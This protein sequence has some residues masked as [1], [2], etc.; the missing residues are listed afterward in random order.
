MPPCL[1][2][3]CLVT[4]LAQHKLGGHGGTC[5][6]T[7]IKQSDTLVGTAERRSGCA[8]VA[9]SP[10]VATFCPSGLRSRVRGS[11]G[12]SLQ[13]TPTTSPPHCMFNP[14]FR[15]RRGDFFACFC[16][17]HIDRRP[18]SR[19]HQG[20]CVL[21]GWCVRAVISSSSPPPSSPLEAAVVCPGPLATH[22][23][24]Q[25]GCSA[26]R[27]TGTIAVRAVLQ[28]CSRSAISRK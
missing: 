5:Q 22:T 1:G 10:R 26:P 3:D 11:C 8:G 19:A 28:P 7:Q 25:F 21:P 24:P 2:A 27:H 20:S 12:R 13:A 23:A 6:P 17:N 14:A 9:V 4:C 15:R 16:E 18:L